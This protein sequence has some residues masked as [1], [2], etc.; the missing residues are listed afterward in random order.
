MRRYAEAKA[1]LARALAFDPNEAITRAY[2]AFVDFEWKADTRP[3][4]QVIASIRATNAAAVP[5]IANFW[6]L[7]ALAERDAVAARDPCMA[8]GAHPLGG[9]NEDITFSQ[10]YLEG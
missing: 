7:C 10:P 8:S 2:H 9:I 4:Q 3:L 5:T 6:L 1:V